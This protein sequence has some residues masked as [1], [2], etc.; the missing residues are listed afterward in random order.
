MSENLPNTRA[1]SIALECKILH[2]WK[3]LAFLC[4]HNHIE[5]IGTKKIKHL[6]INL[7]NVQKLLGKP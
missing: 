5:D 3:S 6:E 1:F 4:K 2:I 7:R